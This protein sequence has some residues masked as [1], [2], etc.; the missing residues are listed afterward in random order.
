MMKAI[1]PAAAKFPVSATDKMDDL[2]QGGGA[3]TI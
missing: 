3:L 2:G 1:R